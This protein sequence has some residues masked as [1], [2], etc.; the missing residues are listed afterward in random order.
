MIALALALQLAAAQAPVVAPGVLSVRSGKAT[1]DIATVQQDGLASVPLSDLPPVLPARDSVTAA[2][3]HVVTL[4]GQHYA[5][6]DGVPYVRAKGTI[7]TMA[8]APEEREGELLIPYCFFADLLP[9][10][11]PERWVYDPA[12][13]EL[14]LLAPGEPRPLI[15]VASAPAPH[16]APAPARPGARKHRWRVVVDAGHGGPDNGMHGPIGADWQIK[17]KDIT[18]AVAKKLAAILQDRGVDVVMTR[19]TDTLIALSDRGRI[20]NERHGDVF[21]SVHVNAAPL[22]WKHPEET[23]GYETYFLREAKT[24]DA[25]RVERMENESVRFETNTTAPQGDPL[26]FVITDMAQNE[27]LRESQEL[28]ALVQTSLGQAS[29]GPSRGVFQAGFRVLV[30]A[31]MP[32]VLVEI[33]FGTNADEARMLNNAKHQR[34]I[35]SAIADA[36]IEYLQHYERRLR[37]ASGA[38]PSKDRGAGTAIAPNQ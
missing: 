12:R 4:A 20:A 36:T 22:D 14:T 24:E 19:T 23:R 33:G 8:V 26:N 1:K 21:V 29:P 30:T 13:R 16:H 35:A 38:A 31:Y 28:A 32:A 7:L 17:E 2:G 6:A 27:H 34:Q 10:L 3:W 5:F 9:R 37:G 25:K 15:A 18:L 11:D